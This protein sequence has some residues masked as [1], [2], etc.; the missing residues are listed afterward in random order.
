ME[1]QISYKTCSP[2]PT[3]DLYILAST[4]R[5][6][7][8]LVP[9]AQRGLEMFGKQEVSWHPLNCIHR[10]QWLNPKSSWDETRAKEQAQKG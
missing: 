5:K 4:S 1:R 10:C 3:E 7:G 6:D 9:K 2:L 8:I